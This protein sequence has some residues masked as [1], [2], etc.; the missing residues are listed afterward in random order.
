MGTAKSSQKVHVPKF[1]DRNLSEFIRDRL[2]MSELI[3]MS[4]NPSQ[5]MFKCEIDC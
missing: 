2:K 1:E 4:K 5:T 3:N